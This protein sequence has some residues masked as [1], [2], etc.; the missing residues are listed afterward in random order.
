MAERLVY[1]VVFDPTVELN[2]IQI[3]VPDVPEVKV[4]GIDEDDAVSKAAHAIGEAL[5]TT[6]EIP[7]PSAPSEIALYG[8][9]RLS[10]IVLDLDEY[11]EQT[12]KPSKKRAK[13]KKS[14]KK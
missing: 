12:K 3:T 10:F 14:S 9:Q 2:R 7:V 1:P 4:L 13:A 5:A 6:T 11:K 8:Q